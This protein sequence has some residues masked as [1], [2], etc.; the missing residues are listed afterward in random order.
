MDTASFLGHAAAAACMGTAIG[1]ERQWGQHPAGLRTNALVAF[2]A[3][4]FVSLPHLLGGSPTSSHLAG[5]VVTGIGFLGGGVILREGLSVR[6]LNTAA[7]MWCSAAVGALT[8]AGLLLEGLAGTVGVLTLNLGLRPVADWVDRRLR[9]ATNVKTTYRLRAT[10]RAGQEGAVRSALLRYFHEHP[11]MTIQGLA[12]QEAGGPDRL[13]VV[14][15]IYSERR[16]DLAMEDLMGQVNN[17]PD[18]TA[19]SWERNPQA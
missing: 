14:A 19:V 5:Q 1:L 6:G 4:L 2:G 3:C 10:C 16:E 15:D 18:V 13:C 12:T 17:E 8:G 11:T 7:T 9:R